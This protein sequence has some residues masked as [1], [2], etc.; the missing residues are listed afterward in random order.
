MDQVHQ[1]D[2]GAWVELSR[3]R[4]DYYNA[5]GAWRDALFEACDAVASHSGPVTS[6]PALSLAECS[7]R[8]HG[9]LYRALREGD[10]D[11]DMVRG[12]LAVH[13]P[14]DWPL[15]F[16]VDATCWPRPEADTSPERTWCYSPSASWNGAPIT[17]GW[18]YQAVVQLGWEASSWVWPV[19]VCR[20][21]ATDDPLEV[22]AQ[23]VR[24]VV[25]RTGATGPVPVFVFDAGYDL[26]G[27]AWLVADVRCTLVGRVRDDRVYWRAAPAPTGG[28]GRPRRHGDPFRLKDPTT[29]GEPEAVAIFNDP[30]C[31]RV[32]VACWAGLHPRL[33]CRGRWAGWDRAPIIEGRLV[34][35]SAERVGKGSVKRGQPLWLFVHAPAGGLADPGL[36][37]RA[38]LRRFDIEHVFRF[39][40]QQLGWTR[41]A[42]MNPAQGDRWTWIVVAAYAQLLLARPLAGDL[43]LP[44]ERPLPCGKLTPVR[45]RRDFG[46]LARMVGTPASP[47]KNRRPGPGRPKGTIKP[48]R[49]RWPVVKRAK[50][51]I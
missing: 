44:W 28:R 50:T 7:R 19:D 41:P 40:K 1:P 18:C 15:V 12:V 13:R 38:Y 25:S 51:K 29:W 2:N 34:R 14:M 8:S 11:P 26:A 16:A 46:R 21:G 43:R 17:P 45:V 47:P 20:I 35:V 27:L 30:A 5:L 42:V 37:A 3:F 49:K 33:A 10:I 36:W 39:W 22:T 32:E 24:G 31:G 9:S 6:A 23:Q 48:P 4:E